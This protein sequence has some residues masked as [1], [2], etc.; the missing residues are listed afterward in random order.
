MTL[1]CSPL[2]DPRRLKVM[3]HGRNV[4]GRQVG[5]AQSIT[6]FR[7]LDNSQISLNT[8]VLLNKSITYLTL[9]LY[10]YNDLIQERYF[11][12]DEI[13]NRWVQN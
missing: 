5:A 3:L 12:K 2:I 4:K 10:Y 6:S 13:T 1:G 7:Q 8:N 9:R 11:K